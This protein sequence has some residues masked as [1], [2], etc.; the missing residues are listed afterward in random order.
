MFTEGWL[1]RRGIIIISRLISH[2]TERVIRLRRVKVVAKRTTESEKRLPTP[3]ADE[4]HA[5]EEFPPLS[6]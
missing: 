6:A 2:K 3:E 4:D 5:P 1:E